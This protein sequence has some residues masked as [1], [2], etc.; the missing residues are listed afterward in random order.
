[1]KIGI[2]LFSIILLS[3]GII[4]SAVSTITKQCELVNYSYGSVANPPQYW[5][6]ELWSVLNKGITRPTNVHC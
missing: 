4:I 1:M 6:E 3:S 2:L 5:R